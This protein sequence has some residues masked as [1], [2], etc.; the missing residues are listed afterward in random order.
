M[1]AAP[2]RGS[3]APL[4]IV[5]VDDHPL[6]LAGI[7]Q[8]IEAEP[9]LTLAGTATT[10]EDA[11][12]LLEGAAPDVA[13]L[14]VSLPGENGF[15]LAKALV[16]GGSEVKVL[17]LSGHDEVPYQRT[18][19][20]IGAHGYLS[21]ACTRAELRDAILTVRA[22]RLSFTPEVM[23][24]RGRGPSIP[25]P[26]R[27]E[28]EVLR[29]IGDGLSNKEI[30]ATLVVSERTVHFHVGNLL[31]KMQAN[32]RTQAVARARELGWLND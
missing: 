15:A 3:C 8:L 5:L 30:A 19:F 14:D 16:A 17:M 1:T 13:I 18:A 27:R 31:A 25:A 22:G 21:K 6:F 28:L 11:T 7:A 4:R 10:A 29:H 9:G 12:Q 32:S 2:A 23:A 26:T 24:E 20:Q